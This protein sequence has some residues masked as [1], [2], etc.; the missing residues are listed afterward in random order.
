MKFIKIHIFNVLKPFIHFLVSVARQFLGFFLNFF[1]ETKKKKEIGAFRTIAAE[2]LSSFFFKFFIF[3]QYFFVPR[4]CSASV[5]DGGR[6][7]SK[8]IF[9]RFS[10]VFVFLF[11][12]CFVCSGAPLA[13]H[14]L[15]ARALLMTKWR[16]RFVPNK[17]KK[18]EKIKQQHHHRHIP[19]GCVELRRPLTW[20]ALRS[21]HRKLGHR[22]KENI[23]PEIVFKFK[24]TVVCRF[25]AIYSSR[26]ENLWLC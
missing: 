4:L 16:P 20:P 15:L 3:F 17:K 19:P 26:F 9:L 18:N 2:T 8:E 21:F 7:R 25:S 10:F 1:I 11:F 14:D 22:P 12:F 6:M 5:A 24:V 13:S 23:N